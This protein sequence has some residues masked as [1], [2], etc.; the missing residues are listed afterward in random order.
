M[1]S[2]GTEREKW[3]EMS[4][5]CYINGSHLVFTCLKLI[6]ETLE[7]GVKHAFGLQLY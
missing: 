6:I 7:Q 2:G 1:F 4:Q 3:L 5:W